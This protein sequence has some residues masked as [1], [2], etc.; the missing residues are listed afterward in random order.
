MAHTYRY[1]RSKADLL[2]PAKGKTA[3]DFFVDWQL[4][5]D[6]QHT[7]LLCAEL[8]RVAY[9]QRELVAASL[10]RAGLALADAGW[11]GGESLGQ[12]WRSLGTDGFVATA[13]GDHPLVV[14]AFRGTE[15]DKPE[16]LL[17]DLKARQVA[18]SFAPGRVHEG[19]LA[20]YQSVR[21][22]LLAVLSALSAHARVVFTGHSLGA[23]VATLATADWRSSRPGSP[24]ELVTFGSPRVGNAVFA[25]SLEGLPM[26]RFVHCA[27]VV[28]RVPPEHVRRDEV[29]DILEGFIHSD[30]LR[31]AL[32]Q[33]VSVAGRLALGDPGFMHVGDLRYIDAHDVLQTTPPDAEGMRLDRE[34]ARKAY[35]AVDDTS[36]LEWAWPDSIDGLVD[37]V[38][39]RDMADH[40]P[41]NYLSAIAA[42]PSA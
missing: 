14:V 12:R 16:D 34:S 40:A 23:A 8:V 11:L 25:A 24:A 18:C 33:A 22:P 36:S 4:P 32:T 19:F 30:V 5:Q 15:P 26:Q 6:I 3:A 38:A 42:S 20:A 13:G 9:A 10:P 7:P 39:W 35:G 2:S 37:L 17:S 28:T 29:A 41:I 31:G 27:D 1:S 21:V